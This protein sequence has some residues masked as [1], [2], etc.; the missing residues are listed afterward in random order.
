MKDSL[1]SITQKLLKENKIS[2]D[3]E[4]LIFQIQSHP[5]YPSLHAITGVLDHF[6]I[7]NIAAE[8]PI[9]NDT[10]K[11]LPDS[12]IAQIVTDTGK[13]LVT[14]SKLQNK[15]A[16]TIFF[17]S[18]KKKEFSVTNFLEVFTGIIVVVEKTENQQQK[19]K[20]KFISTVLLSAIILLTIVL[21]ITKNTSV[22][23]F[24]YIG[25]SVFGVVVSYSITKQELGTTTAIGE[26]FCSGNND[27]KDCDAVLNSKG[28][29]LVKE[30]KISD[31]S[32]I[33][34]SGLLLSTLLTSNYN[35]LY[36][37]SFLALPITF[38][39]IYY[40]YKIVKTWCVLCLTI[41]GALWL[42]ASLG[43]M[44]VVNI[45]SA[46]TNT[47]NLIVTLIVFIS[48]YL[49]WYYI[50][51]LA[52]GV[53]E[54]QKDKI[55]SIRFKRNYT[56]FN[57]LLQKSSTKNTVISDGR[58]IIF[59][60]K[61][62][63]LE[64]TIITNPFCSHC[65]PVHETLNE[66][67]KKYNQLVKIIIRFSVST[68][69]IKSSDVIVTTRLLELYNSKK[70]ND[71]KLAMNDIYHGMPYKKWLSKWQTTNETSQYLEVLQNEKS[72]C[73][74]HAINFTP[75]ILINGKSFPKEYKRT[76]LIFFIEDLQES[77]Q[78]I[79]PLVI[80]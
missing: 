43:F 46:L 6:N 62:S 52:K 40:Q 26:T 16:Y 25:L 74:D 54:L 15:S 63:K 44:K 14:V 7:E 47:N 8:V 34:F 20:N 65:K 49:C 1:I 39:S 42:Q 33:Y 45:S 17:E 10:L 64:I 28:A 75:E 59:G 13:D 71:C 9:N 55:E 5:S 51:P 35:P 18:K 73:N 31:L 50:K 37:I 38:Y 67:L 79:Q 19:T 68:N 36:L 12:F 41:I 3:K 21:L 22:L 24:V 78:I 77:S 80:K 60:N 58:E 30:H 76:D 57:S 29:T 27:K 4:E 61:E 66:I 53:I 11:Q 48:I 32:I 23:D 69:N 56:L 72:W 2:F 70:L